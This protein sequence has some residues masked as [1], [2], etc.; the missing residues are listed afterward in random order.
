MVSR[1]PNERGRQL[2]RLLFLSR[3]I[4]HDLDVSVY[5]TGNHDPAAREIGQDR[6]FG[7]VLRQAADDG[8]LRL[9]PGN[10]LRCPYPL[11]FLLRDSHASTRKLDSVGIAG[12]GCGAAPRWRALRW[13]R[14][15]TIHRTPALFVG[16]RCSVARHGTRPQ[17][18]LAQRR[19]RARGLKIRGIHSA[20]WFELTTEGR[21]RTRRLNPAGLSLPFADRGLLLLTRSFAMLWGNSR[22][23]GGPPLLEPSFN[24]KRDTA[25][26]PSS[27][28]LVAPVSKAS[29]RAAL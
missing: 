8:I 24:V 4:F 18:P 6:D 27:G 21:L 26:N 11:L 28:F 9:E 10:V 17:V 2:R 15:G 1:F 25:H 19:G 7:F 14:Q 22:K 23:S 5:L 12:M 20:R 3:P 29:T 16:P 13:P